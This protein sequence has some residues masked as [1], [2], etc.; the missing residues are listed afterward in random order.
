ML[1]FQHFTLARTSERFASYGCPMTVLTRPMRT[2]IFVALCVPCIASAQ[3]PVPQSNVPTANFGHSIPVPSAIATRRAAPI[4][5]DAKLDEEA[6]KAATPI[7][8]FTQLDPDE[9]KPASQRTEVRF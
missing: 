8:E 6:W 4:T 5:L 7:T 1:A 9:G 2:S 3:A